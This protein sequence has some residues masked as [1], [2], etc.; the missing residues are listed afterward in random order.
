MKQCLSTIGFSHGEFTITRMF[1]V[2]QLV[3]QLHNLVTPF[4]KD[5]QPEKIVG[6]T[7]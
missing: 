6:L 3:V 5:S 1:F 4:T 2:V 7:R